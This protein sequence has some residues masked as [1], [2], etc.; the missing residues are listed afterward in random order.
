MEEDDEWELCNDDGFVYKRKRRRID[1]SPAATDN[2]AAAALAAENE[3]R[4]RERKKRTLLK[5]RTKYENEIREW[6]TLSNT[7]RAMQNA[8]FQQQQQRQQEQ[9]R[10]SEDPSSL[11]STSTDSVG[12]SLLDEL[13]LQVETQEAV[14]QD[15]SN[16][17]DVAESVCFKR[18]E[19]FKRSL[20]DLPIW[21]SPAELMQA[22][23]D[24]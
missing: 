14:I 24:E 22:L 19:Q 18:E 7:L 4:R 12:G 23:C 17:C 20:F 10:A 9:E 11:P 15:I 21:S 16:L 5:L 1:P 13:L 3:N 8:A 2:A 6:D